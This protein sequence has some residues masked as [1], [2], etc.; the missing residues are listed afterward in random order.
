MAEKKC[1]LW[2]VCTVNLDYQL[3]LIEE[4]DKYKTSC[5]KIFLIFPQIKS[6]HMISKINFYWQKCV[7]WKLMSED[8]T[9]YGK[10]N[11]IFRWI[12]Y[13]LESRRKVTHECTH[14]AEIVFVVCPSIYTLVWA[15]NK[16][17]NCSV[18]LCVVLNA[19]AVRLDLFYN[20]F[21]F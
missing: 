3:S 1:L 5:I 8:M 20:G 19:G 13:M 17:R 16:Y 18:W 12:V 21:K 15:L 10:I 4:V 11:S 7:T 2:V 6:I 14:N 9:N